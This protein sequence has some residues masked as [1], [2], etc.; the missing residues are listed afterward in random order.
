MQ[1]LLIMLKKATAAILASSFAACVRPYANFAIETTPAAGMMKSKTIS[2][3]LPDNASALA[4]NTNN[5]VIAQLKREGF[6]YVP[7]G[8]KVT[9]QVDAWRGNK[10]V[11][12]RVGYRLF[13]ADVEE[14]YAD[15]VTIEL[16]AVENGRGIWDGS[17][18]GLGEYLS[19]K[20]APGCVRTLLDRYLTHESGEETCFRPDQM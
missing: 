6:K 4:A 19:G 13:H 15:V 9:M 7:L 18:E 16:N 3:K 11:G 5:V 17:I 8:G 10:T 12:Q 14:E 2:T 1:A 20:Y